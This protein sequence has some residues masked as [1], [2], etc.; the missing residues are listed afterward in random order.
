MS[1]YQTQILALAAIASS[2]VNSSALSE[3]VMPQISSAGTGPSVVQKTY[4]WAGQ[5]LT[6]TDLIAP[7]VGK[8]G[9]VSIPVIKDGQI[10]SA[11]LNKDNVFQVSTL[12]TKEQIVKST[13][14]GIGELISKPFLIKAGMDSLEFQITGKGAMSSTYAKLEVSVD[15]GKSQTWS[16]L[17]PISATS[18]QP[19]KWDLKSLREKNQGKDIVARV[20]LVDGSASE[21]IGVGEVSALSKEKPAINVPPGLRGNFINNYAFLPTSRNYVAVGKFGNFSSSLTEAEL[22][23]FIDT[24]AVTSYSAPKLNIAPGMPLKELSN[25]LLETSDALIDK[26]G[27]DKTDVVLRETSFVNMVGCWVAS[28]VPYDTEMLSLQPAEMVRMSDPQYILNRR[29]FGAVCGGHACLV[30][31]LIRAQSSNLGIK[32]QYVSGYFR[33]LNGAITPGPD[34]AWAVAILSNGMQIPVDA[35]LPVR[36]KD[37]NLCFRSVRKIYRDMVAPISKDDTELFLARYF[38]GT[39]GLNKIM[40]SDPQDRG[41]LTALTFDQWKAIS[42]AYLMKLEKYIRDCEIRGVAVK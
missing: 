23:Y 3:L 20:S 7:I 4:Y 6:T 32:A 26:S 30:R 28:H 22:D 10:S 16:K 13:L 29:K 35:S 12:D 34:H 8:N 1:N 9:A 19:V 41:L 24:V 27:L 2:S 39:N 14:S 33:E 38:P 36:G 40:Y 25:L 21:V 11:W 15:G 42:P 18:L 17:A 37:T 5:S 31:D